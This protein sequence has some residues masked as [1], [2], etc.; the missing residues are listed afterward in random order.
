MSRLLAWLLRVFG[1]R[2]RLSPIVVE[3]LER[4]GRIGKTDQ[5]PSEL[6]PLAARLWSRGW[7]NHKILDSM[8]D[9]I[10]PY[11]ATRQLDPTDCGFVGYALL[12]V[13]I[14]LT[15]RNWTAL[16]NPE[17]RYEAIV[18]PRGLITPQ[19]NEWGWSFDA[20][21]RVDGETYFPSRLDEKTITQQLHENLPFVQTQYQAA[22]LRV[23]Q[24]AFAT[25]ANDETEWLIAA[26]T[27]ENPRG[28]AQSANLFLALRPFNPEGVAVIDNVELRGTELW[29]NESLGAILPTPDA[30]ATSDFENGDVASH[31][32]ALNNRSNISDK[33]GLATFV[34][35]YEIELR[36]HTHRVITVAMPLTKRNE[37]SAGVVQWLEPNAL[38]QLK[39]DF[40]NRWRTLLAQ[41][42]TIHVPDDAVQNAF[43]A[44]K[45]HLLVL[46]D[47]DSITPG[48]FL[49]HEFW[50]RDAAFMLHALD[51]LGYHEQVKNVLKTFP[52]YLRK[53]G[54]VQSQEGE[55]DSNGQAL[56]LLE[57]NARLS[58]DY[59]ILHDEYWQALNAAHWID[60]ARQKTK[61]RDDRVPEHGLLPAG[62]SA[63]H[64]GA[65]DFY[66]WDDWW[67][68]AG[69]R[70]AS[71]AAKT[72][73]SPEDAQK[74]QTAYDAF[75][76]DVNDALAR[77]AEKNNAD[78]MPASPYR[79]ADSAMVSNLIASYPLQLVAPDDPRLVATIAE[80]R[81][82]AFVDGAFF[83][84]VGHGGFG[85]YLALHI[86]GAEIF[87]RKRD[88][89]DA[90]RFLLKHAS[91]T[92]TWGETIHP[93]TKRGGHGDGHHGWAAADVVS[94][95][96]NALLFEEDDH[97]VLTPALPDDWVFETAALKVERAAT[98]FGDVDFTLAFGE[99]NATLVLQGKWRVPPA[100]IEWNLPIEIKDA[101]G[102]IAGVELLNAHQI[103]FPNNVTRIVATF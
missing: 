84:H 75:F 6:I 89:W 63:E 85:T 92:W 101:G 91:P 4:S 45:A 31:L 95:V 21:L 46:H 81:K 20:W 90:F 25:R 53:D 52:R 19:P 78:W 100:Y 10:L 65:N 66:F 33:T 64:L 37:A 17:S 54:F 47:G 1:P 80:L 16:G 49:Y 51:Q 82:I 8:R 86:A 55:W 74:L 13:Q 76:H 15:Y 11:W 102:N 58:G 48:P 32:D 67:G 30:F 62:M 94:F 50:W 56:W 77:A 39:R 22:R 71:F 29:I 103:R 72:F 99:H 24:E 57:Q 26:Y 83:H 2:Y 96:R 14:N 41:G 28:D 87:Q 7:Y 3:Y 70:S 27:I 44:N 69:L 59:E 43:D 60:A 40:S 73:N 18:D 42:M 88:G 34:A 35:A 9:W 97:L 79:R 68:L 12:P 61:R 38:A 23:N 93:I 5:I 36:P 98:Y